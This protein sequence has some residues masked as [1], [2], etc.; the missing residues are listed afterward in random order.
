VGFKSPRGVVDSVTEKDI[1]SRFGVIQIIKW[2][3]EF[4]KL[5]KYL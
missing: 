5:D 3:A 4:P 1:D 2:K